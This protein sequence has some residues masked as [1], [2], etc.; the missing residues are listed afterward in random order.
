MDR[1]NKTYKYSKGIYTANVYA[2]GT[3]DLLYHDSKITDSNIES[4]VN[5]T[6]VVAGLGNATQI[7][8][9]DSAKFNIT[10][11]AQDIDLRQYQLQTGGT[12]GYNGVTMTCELITPASTSL[13][14]TGTPVSPYGSDSVPCYING[15][16]TAYALDPDTRTVQSF[17]AVAGESYHVRYY[18]AKP[19]SEVLDIGALFRPEIVSLELKLP[20]YA[21][22][23]GR[24]AAT[25][26]LVGNL[27][28][29][30]PRYQ[31]NG[32]AG[33]NAS[34]TEALSAS[35]SGQALAYEDLSGT[36]CDSSSLSSLMYLV[37]E[38]ENAV[39]GVEDLAVIGGGL[40]LSVGESRLLPVKAV[41]ADGLLAQPDYSA[42][43]C[44]SS[45]PTKA[46]VSAGVVTGVAAG[47]C[48]VTVTWTEAGVSCTVPVSVES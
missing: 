20:I 5:I 1:F 36:D 24:S 29:I 27:W 34:Q 31:F 48:S 18:V 2:L 39:E 41:M 33:L 46:A 8:L 6:E 11:T 42:L 40:D 32:S 44:V 4:S 23:T 12:M 38:P 7:M 35:L 3:R 13:T 22:M 16:G 19:A 15:A 26:S 28:V 30:C 17:V 47:A 43:T 14:V 25:G 37:W 21:A 45:D 9:F 10:L